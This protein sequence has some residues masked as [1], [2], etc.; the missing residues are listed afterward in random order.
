MHSLILFV[1][2][3]SFLSR[4]FFFTWRF[5]YMIKA[6]SVVINQRFHFDIEEKK[7]TAKMVYIFYRLFKGSFFSLVFLLLLFY[8]FI[9]VS[10]KLNFRFT[11]QKISSLTNCDW[12]WLLTKC[13]SLIWD[14]SCKNSHT[15]QHYQI[16]V[17]H[18]Q[19][20][21]LVNVLC[22]EKMNKNSEKAYLSRLSI[23]L[24]AFFF[25]ECHF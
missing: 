25:V 19:S 4:F 7:N 8:P 5:V 1:F 3:F 21:F 11:F 16:R 9:S 22:I 20:A 17:V 10:F 18:R 14:I 15:Q 13:G 12:N 23:N 24:R 2:F 6:N